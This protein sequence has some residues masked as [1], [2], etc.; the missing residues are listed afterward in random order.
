MKMVDFVKKISEYAKSIQSNFIIVPQNGEYLG[1]YELFLSAIDGIGR[2]D[3]FFKDNSRNDPEEQ[4]YVVKYLKFFLK[5][6]KFILNT[7]YCT[8]SNLIAE[9]YSKSY[10]NGFICYVGIRDL[11]QIIIHRYFEPNLITA[12]YSLINSKKLMINEKKANIDAKK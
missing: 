3:I 11:D 1:Q 4:Y 5:A 12:K 6:N 10:E 8:R 7:E 9:A 2:E